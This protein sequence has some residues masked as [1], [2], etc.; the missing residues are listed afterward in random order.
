MDEDYFDFLKRE[1]AR[2]ILEAASRMEEAEIILAK[3]E[4][5]GISKNIR[6][7]ASVDRELAVMGIR[8]LKNRKPITTLVNFACHPETLWS[9]NR[10]ITADFP[11]YLCDTIE[12][13]WGGL[14]LYVNGA[15]GGMVTVDIKMDEKGRELH[16]FQEAERIGVTLAKRSLESLMEAR[17]S[18]LP[19]IRVRKK[20]VAVPLQNF[21]FRLVRWLG[22]IDR[23]L[24]ENRVLTEVWYMDL[25]DAQIVLRRPG[26][27]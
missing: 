13:K 5:L 6:N 23:P 21:R 19:W 16:V 22:V 7:E 20:E 15:L 17:P 4:I 14:A 27:P 18:L 9:D 8:S 3:R 2:V 12:R 1:V 10:M 24:T 11:G 26:R 25:G